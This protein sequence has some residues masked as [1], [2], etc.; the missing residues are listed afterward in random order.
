MSRQSQLVK[1][2]VADQSDDKHVGEVHQKKEK[3]N[4]ARTSVHDV[5]DNNPL[6]KPII[7]PDVIVHTNKMKFA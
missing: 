4:P 2:Q 6:V 1:F 5:R 3:P 7:V